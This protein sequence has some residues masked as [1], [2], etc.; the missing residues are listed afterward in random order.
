MKPAHIEKY[1]HGP[2]SEQY[3]ESRIKNQESGIRN[4]IVEESRL[5]CRFHVRKGNVIIVTS[6]K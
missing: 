3:Q 1:G 6:V 5:A 2:Y 4:R